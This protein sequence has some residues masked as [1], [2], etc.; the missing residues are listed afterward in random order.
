MQTEEGWLS[1]D[2]HPQAG[3]CEGRKRLG[4]LNGHPISDDELE[5]RLAA[6][7]PCVHTYRVPLCAGIADGQPC[8]KCGEPYRLRRSA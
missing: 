5:L 1:F 2:V 3:R 7:E 6:L 4:W 8:S